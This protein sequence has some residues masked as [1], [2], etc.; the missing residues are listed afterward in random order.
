MPDLFEPTDAQILTSDLYKA[1]EAVVADLRAKDP[2]LE[3]TPLPEHVEALIN[4]E[5]KIFEPRTFPMEYKGLNGTEI[6]NSSADFWRANKNA[7][8]A[9]LLKAGWSVAR[10]TID[11]E[12]QLTAEEWARVQKSE[13][14]VID[15]RLI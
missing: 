6:L 12:N 1:L 3:P 4:P 2:P 10:W 11:E 5:G 7:G 15:G 13:G 9:R 14:R 8:Y